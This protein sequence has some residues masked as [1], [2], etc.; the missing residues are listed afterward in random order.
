MPQ[1]S[2]HQ[3][4]AVSVTYTTAHGSARSLTHWERPGIEPTTSWFLVG[5]VNHCTM[6]R[7]PQ[8]IILKLMVFFNVCFQI[9]IL[10]F[11]IFFLLLKWIYHICSC[12]MIITIWF[13]RISITQPR[14][15]PPTHWTRPGIEPETSWFL[16]GFVNHWAMT[17]TPRVTF[18]FY[19]FYFIFHFF[20]TQ[21]NLS[22]L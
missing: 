21:M 22:H 2:Q 1:P 5:F 12:I 9:F 4:W 3:I 10:F 16:V 19:L 15:I 13:H 20:I 7:T 18:L 6:T 11:S 14:H 8:S 17:G